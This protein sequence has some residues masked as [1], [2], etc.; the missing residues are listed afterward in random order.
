MKALKWTLASLVLLGFA[1]P[2]RGQPLP[3]PGQ[4]PP[5]APPAG[6]NPMGNVPLGNM[7]M[8]N[9]PA[10][11][12]NAVPDGSYPAGPMQ[13][14]GGESYG[15]PISGSYGDTS[16]SAC[17]DAGC[18]PVFDNVY[19]S[20]G[21]FFFRAE[22]FM[23][24]RS[25]HSPN[26]ELVATS[27]TNVVLHTSDLNFR[28]E[29]GQRFEAGY[30]FNE[31]ASLG[32]TFWEVQDWNPIVSTFS[33]TSSL[34]L[35]GGA[36]QNSANFNNAMSMEAQYRTMIKNYEI[37]WTNATIFD[38]LSLLAG[39]RY[40]DM[41][42]R[43]AIISTRNIGDVTQVGTSDYI[44]RTT[45]RLLG[46]QI[47][48]KIQY[49]IDLW[50]LEFTGKSGLY[51]DGIQFSKFYGDRNNTV[52]VNPQAAPPVAHSLA[53][54]NEVNLS[55]SRK[56]GNHLAVRGG[57]NAIWITNVGLAADHFDPSI[58][59]VNNN[60]VREGGDLFLHG[61]NAGVDVRY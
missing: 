42:D 16:G 29:V 56:L 34:T 49:D 18:P 1:D 41:I 52:V 15:G 14:Y 17:Y 36:G 24:R 27:A 53:A 10:L 61:V 19:S 35:A 43:L 7:P 13:N 50:S 33:N 4:Q 39:M 38:R 3:A 9:G 6:V 45:N 51:D 32:F 21:T 12:P 48:A 20:P 46:G 8:G 23:L 59:H 55:F 28:N 22:A 58:N 30:E 57:Y 40:M 54:I 37:N 44:M 47:G 5:P 11:A 26:R 25:N 60:V 2:S 31:C